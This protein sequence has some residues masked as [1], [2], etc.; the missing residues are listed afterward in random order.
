MCS[1][2]LAE[3]PHP[4]PTRGGGRP[5][6]LRYV[7][8]A[9]AERVVVLMGSGVGAAAEAIEALVAAGEKVGLLIVRLYRPFDTA[10]FLDVLP[11]TTR[12]VAVLDRTKEPGATRA[13]LFGDVVITL[14]AA[15]AGG[16]TTPRVI[17]G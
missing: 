16:R 13:P 3:P 17:G 11:E 1:S 5:G 14:A 12:V 10:A 15:A 9:K 7:G 8:H 4:S 6:L 2:R